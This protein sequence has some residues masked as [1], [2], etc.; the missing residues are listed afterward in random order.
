MTSVSSLSE[1]FDGSGLGVGGGSSNTVLGDAKVV[2][3][4]AEVE[5]TVVTP[6]GSPRVATDPV[7]LASVGVSAVADDGDLVVDQREEDLLRVDVVANTFL[8]ANVVLLEVG[9]SVDTARDGSVEVELLHHGVLSADGVVLGNVVLGVVDSP[10]VVERVI[11]LSVGRPGAVTADINVL[12]H[13]ALEVVG[14]VLLARRVGDTGLVGILVDL[15]GVATI[16]RAA[17]LAVN[18]GLSIESNRGGG[19]VLV[20]DVE[21]ISD[22]RGGALGPA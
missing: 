22:G 9:G 13:T 6:V 19:E 16:A 3:I 17:S 11:A 10:A 18:N 1:L 4:H 14:G 20:E 7:L 21:S 2:T 15:S 5:E 8:D 12:A